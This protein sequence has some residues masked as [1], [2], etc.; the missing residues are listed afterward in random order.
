[1]YVW[2][3]GNDP[4]EWMA[5][6]RIL[7]SLRNEVPSDSSLA[8]EESRDTKARAEK[9]SFMVWKRCNYFYFFDE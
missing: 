5:S 1:M 3:C 6:S 8:V 4:K 2:G 9:E 7:I